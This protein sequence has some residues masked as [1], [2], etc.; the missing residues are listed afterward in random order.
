MSFSTRL[1]YCAE[2]SNH[3]GRGCAAGN[4]RNPK[5]RA[6]PAT[7]SES[8]TREN[9]VSVGFSSRDVGGLLLLYVLF[10]V[11]FVHGLGRT[12]GA[13]PIS[14]LYTAMYVSFFVFPMFG[15]VSF[16]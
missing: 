2:N 10:K 15:I 8:E 12:A 3:S 16:S 9:R 4:T 14:N 1:D 6:G 11:F 7:I 13:D 5:S